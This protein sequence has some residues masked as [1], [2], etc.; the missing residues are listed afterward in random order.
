MGSGGL[1]GFSSDCTGVILC[2][3]M[4]WDQL[5]ILE[6]MEELKLHHFQTGNV[7]LPPSCQ[8]EKS[9]CWTKWDSIPPIYLAGEEAKALIKH[10]RKQSASP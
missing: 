8:E 10:F 3:R 4:V 6:A 1:R 5:F 7:Q 2:Y 9:Q